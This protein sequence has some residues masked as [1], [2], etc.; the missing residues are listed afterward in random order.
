MRS[1]LTLAP[2]QN[3][4]NRQAP[5]PPAHYNH[6][7]QPTPVGAAPSVPVDRT[8]WQTQLL[9]GSSVLPEQFF[10]PQTSFFTGRPVAALLRA[11][12]EDALA[13]F[14]SQFMTE[15]RRAQREAREAEAWF[16]SEDSCSPF[17]FESICA[18][19]GLESGAIRQ[20]LKRWRHSREVMPQRK[21]RRV[22]VRQPHQGIGSLR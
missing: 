20:Q 13:C 1:Q 21:I 5:Q 2:Q 6:A 18:V 3:E 15:G 19:L 22:A 10:N 14:Q 11:V 8:P 9:S 17:S 16:L 4:T 12:L 7:R